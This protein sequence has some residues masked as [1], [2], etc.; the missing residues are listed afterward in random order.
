MDQVRYTMPMT[1]YGL[2]EGNWLALTIIADA[3]SRATWG[4]IHQLLNIIL[5]L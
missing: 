1:H 4:A 3:D 2:Q 5:Q